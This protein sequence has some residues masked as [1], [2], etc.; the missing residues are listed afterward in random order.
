M[1]YPMKNTCA[2]LI[3]IYRSEFDQDEYF[4]VKSSLI[5][6]QN[7]D[8]YW[9]APENINKTYYI[10]NFKINNFSLFKNIYFNNIQ[11]YNKLLTSISFYKRFENY[12]YVLILQPDAIILNNDLAFWTQQNYDYIGAPWPKGFSLPINIK[13]IPIDD[14]ILCTTFVGNGGLSLRNINACINLLEEFNDVAN[15]WREVGHAEDLFF[16]FLGNL[17]L[18]FRLPNIVTAANFSHDI[19][20]IYLNKLIKNKSPFGVHA[21]AK[22]ERNFWENRINWPSFKN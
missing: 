3:P 1:E 11:G 5:H 21:W 15:Q 7:Y 13:N 20:P 12:S 17:S 6:L 10:D 8:I 14:D 16:S 4:S 9:V 18:N 19:D 22:Y 2:I